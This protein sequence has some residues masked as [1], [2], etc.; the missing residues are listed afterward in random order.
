MRLFLTRTKAQVSAMGIVRK[1]RHTDI[2]LH[3]MTFF[4]ERRTYSAV[5]IRRGGFGEQMQPHS[6]TQ[7]TTA[8][9][10]APRIDCSAEDSAAKRELEL[11]W[12]LQKNLSK[13]AP[14]TLSCRSTALHSTH[15]TEALTLPACEGGMGKD[16]AAT[17]ALSA[18]VAVSP[19][20]RASTRYGTL[21]PM[22]WPEISI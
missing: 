9:T 11:W 15:C 16:C 6:D 22:L 1:K 20:S 19:K 21:A 10:G 12:V 8:W 14:S 17:R 18:A 4:N 3:D 2:E 7:C 13:Q 5:V